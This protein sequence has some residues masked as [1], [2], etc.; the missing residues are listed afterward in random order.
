MNILIIKD[1]RLI[2][3][4]LIFPIYSHNRSST[5]RFLKWS[6]FTST[7]KELLFVTAY[8]GKITY[9]K[10]DVNGWDSLE[11]ACS[12]FYIILA[13]G[14]E[15]ITYITYKQKCSHTQISPGL[16]KSRHKLSIIL[17]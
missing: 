6:H 7:L 11:R 5:G 8:S 9:S 10:G 12:E 14:E 13:L 3:Q 2:A 4:S 1:N 15:V 17:C 16:P